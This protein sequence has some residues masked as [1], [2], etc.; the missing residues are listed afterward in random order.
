MSRVEKHNPLKR[1]A[2]SRKRDGLKGAGGKVA[3][4]EITFQSVKEDALQFGLATDVLYQMKS[5]KEASIFLAKWKD[6]PIILKAYRL[7]HSSHKMSKSQGYIASGTSKRTHCILGMIE[8]LAV[9]EYDVLM[10]SFKA[11][12]HVPTPISRVGNYLTMRFIGDGL[13]PAPKL[14]DVHLDD[15]EVV[16]DQILDDFLIMYRDAH[17]V[18]GDLSAYNILWWKDRAWIIDVPQAYKVGV[19]SD[20]RK[21]EVLLHRD[22]KNVL[23]YF[24]SYGISKDSEHI[25]EVFLDAYMPHNLRHYKE[26]AFEG[27]GDL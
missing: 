17:Y 13:K 8:D 21:A 14:K 18:H 23:K 7:W 5:G 22:I 20:M 15:P 12:V 6:H 4:S 19:H 3:I 16:L 1:G 9:I 2:M 25:L 10:N 11:G 27:G 24:E 26:L